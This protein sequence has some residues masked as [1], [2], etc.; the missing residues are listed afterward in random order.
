MFVRIP[1]ET[2]Q[3]QECR[4]YIV[5]KN[6]QRT[7]IVLVYVPGQTGDGVRVEYATGQWRIEFEKSREWAIQ[8]LPIGDYQLWAR[9]GEDTGDDTG[10][11]VLAQKEFQV[12]EPADDLPL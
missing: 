4:L 1:G 8:N 5:P 9:P 7:R 3:T 11:G 2:W 10:D 12:I 6:R